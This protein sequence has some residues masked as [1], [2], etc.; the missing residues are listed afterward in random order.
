MYW[1]FCLIL[2]HLLPP[3]LCHSVVFVGKKLCSMFSFSAHAG[4]LLGT[5]DIIGGVTLQW[6]NI[7]SMGD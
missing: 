6:T 7:P 2:Q 3:G 4:V 1:K 5:G